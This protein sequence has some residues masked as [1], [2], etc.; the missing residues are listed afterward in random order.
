MTS[1]QEGHPFLNSGVPDPR[2]YLSSTRGDFVTSCTF[3]CYYVHFR[4]IHHG[5]FNKEALAD[6]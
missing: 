6:L 3:L 5:V 2:D 4:V 1:K